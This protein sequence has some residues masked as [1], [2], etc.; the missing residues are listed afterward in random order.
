MTRRFLRDNL[1]ATRQQVRAAL[2]GIEPHPLGSAY[3]LGTITVKHRDGSSRT[4]RT[5]IARVSAVDLNEAIAR[6]E[7]VDGVSVLSYN[8]QFV[9]PPLCSR[10]ERRAS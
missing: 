7:S 9:T 4:V 3:L 8:L 6:A 2:E 5:R 10:L 1:I